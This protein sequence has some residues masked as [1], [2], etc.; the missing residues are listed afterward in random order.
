VARYCRPL[1]TELRE[2]QQLHSVLPAPAQQ[3]LPAPAQQAAPPPRPSSLAKQWTLK[4]ATAEAKPHS[5]LHREQALSLPRYISTDK[6]PL[7]C[8]RARLRLANSRLHAHL[9]RRHLT[10]S[11]SCPHCGGVPETAE[12][13]LEDCPTY[14]LKRQR[15]KQALLSIQVP[16]SAHL[17][18]GTLPAALRPSVADQILACTGEFITAIQHA[19]CF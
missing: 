11:A 14:A 2:I 19:R 9:F 15:C 5:P 10:P 7:A 12:H 4:A 18:L 6:K 3:V 17:C 8:H 1:H 13:I 16:F